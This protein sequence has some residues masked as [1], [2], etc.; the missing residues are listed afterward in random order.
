[1]IH[2]HPIPTL[3]ELMN[4]YTLHYRQSYKST[5]SPKPKHILRAGKSA[6]ERLDRLKPVSKPG[7]TLLDVG[8][9]GGEF[10]YLAGRAGFI[11]S[12]IEPNEGY[13]SYSREHYG[14]HVR[15]GT[16]ETAD[17]SRESIDIITLHHVL[18]HIQYPLSALIQLHEWL[19]PG[20]HLMI[21]VPDME[22]LRHAPSTQFHYAHIY[23]FNHATLKAV[24]HK[25]GFTP[26][27]A[28][29]RTT[30]I[31]FHK[32]H[33]PQRDLVM[34]DEANYRH[35]YQRLRSHTRLS[36]YTSLTPYQRLY[37]KAWKYGLEKMHLRGHADSRAILDQLSPTAN[38]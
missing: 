35:L 17:I 13:A 37:G 36:H 2:S 22:S 33:E 38:H 23:N 11:A 31:L 8:S 5:Y 7:L 29:V 14:I 27:N 30:T 1:M 16:W 21:D 3:E 9:G 26:H 18:E 12:G 20:G 24:A 25:A 34:R 15:P 32:T 6:L 19:K 28:S 4:Y 10:V